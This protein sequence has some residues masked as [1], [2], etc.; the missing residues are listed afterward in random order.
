MSAETVRYATD[1]IQANA[2]GMLRWSK[3]EKQMLGVIRNV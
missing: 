2:S 3:F 1:R